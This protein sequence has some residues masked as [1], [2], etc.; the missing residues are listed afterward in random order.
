MYYYLRDYQSSAK[1]YQKFLT[2]RSAYNLDIYRSENAKIGYV[3]NEV[4]LTEESNKLFEEFKLYAEN[5]PSIY[6]NINLAMYYSYQ[7]D[8]QKALDNLENFSNESNFHYWT[9]LFVGQDPLMDNIKNMSEYKK[10]LKTIEKRF[11]ERHQKI[12]NSLEEMNLL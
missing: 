11:W 10:L 12:K 4:G 1:Y 3:L 2:I 6:R 7:N 8:T 9:I 5:D